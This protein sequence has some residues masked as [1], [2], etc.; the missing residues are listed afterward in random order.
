MG[1]G[2]E[3]RNEAPRDQARFLRREP[4]PPRRR[5]RRA[6]CLD[7]AQSRDLPGGL[8]IPPVA[9]ARAGT[10]QRDVV[11][12]LLANVRTPR[13]REGDL[14]AQ[15]AACRLGERRLQELLQRHGTTRTELYLDA[16]QNYSAR[17][18]KDALAKIPPG[19]Y[20]ADDYLDDD[21]YGPEPI[22]LCVAIKLARGRAEVDF[23]GTSPQCP[24]SVNAVFAITYSATF[25]V[26]RCLLGRTFRPAPG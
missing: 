15:V 4:R 26:F 19:L 23:Q 5:G 24:G 10:I 21:G 1:G 25:Y 17:L 22:R 8:R 12:I 3:C 18:M 13:E 6:T 20:R 7:G 2:A 16:L 9:L 11:G 14:M